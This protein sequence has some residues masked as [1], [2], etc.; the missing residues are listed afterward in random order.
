MIR[1]ATRPKSWPVSADII[2]L[3]PDEQ[4]TAIPPQPGPSKAIMPPGFDSLLGL[5]LTEMSPDRVVGK[6]TV[7]ERHQQPYGVTHGG[8]HCSVVET[9]ASTGAALWAME[10]G[11]AGVVGV[12]NSTDFLRSHREGP[13]TAVAT[14]IHRGRMQQLWTVEVRRDSDEK[15]VSRGQVRLQNL[16]DT[17]AIGGITPPGEFREVPLDGK[18]SS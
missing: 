12:S 1:I 13:L 9:L 7:D 8:I 14:P 2:P 6:L 10:A 16:V 11:L 15:V 17:V 18:G 3:M 5:S 4:I